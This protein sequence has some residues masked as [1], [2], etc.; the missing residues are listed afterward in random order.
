MEHN[1][2]CPS[3]ARPWHSQLQ[4][5]AG[6]PGPWRGKVA[7]LGGKAGVAEPLPISLSWVHGPLKTQI[8]KSHCIINRIYVKWAALGSS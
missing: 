5:A 3:G 6:G 7:L 2:L 1:G 4:T 8:L